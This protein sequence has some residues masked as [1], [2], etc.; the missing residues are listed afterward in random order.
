MRRPACVVHECSCIH[1]TSQTTGTSA[2]GRQVDRLSFIQGRKGRW[3]LGAIFALTAAW[4]AL[5]VASVFFLSEDSRPLRARLSVIIFTLAIGCVALLIENLS[6]QHFRMLRGFQAIHRHVL[7]C[8]LDGNVINEIQ[9][10]LPGP[11]LDTAMSLIEDIQ[12][13]C[14]RFETLENARSAAEVRARRNKAKYEHF[15]AVLNCLPEPV[16]VV[17]QFDELVQANPVARR[18]FGMPAG[19]LEKQKLSQAIDCPKLVDILIDT[20]RRK[21]ATQRTGEIELPDGDDQTRSF[22]VI[23]RTLPAKN[24]GADSQKGASQG[25]VAVL[26]DISGSKAAQKRNAEFVSAVSHEMKTPLSGIKA[27][28]ELLVDGDAE[29]EQTREDFLHVI[30]SQANRLQ[31]L[32]DNLLNLARIEAGVVQVSKQPLSLNELLDETLNI[33]RPAAEAKQITLHCDLS[34]LYL[35][36]LA[37]RDMLIQAAIN[38]LSNAIKY[39]APGGRVTLRSRMQDDRVSFSVEDSGVGLSPEDQVKV[40]EKFY[41]VAKDREMASGTGLGLPLALHIVED[42]HGGQLSVQSTLGRGSTFTIQLPAPAQL[43]MA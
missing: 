22:S 28:V 17:D 7:E 2:R 19:T 1:R 31:R 24:D 40:F 4:L 21:G 20:R 15:E 9:A 26:R 3:L 43:Q 10:M 29:D 39:T 42:V 12:G 36:V 41:R 27:Y 16:L 23:A 18:M 33:V 11:G 13:M 30:E 14:Q 8:S 5:W 6:Q 35:G 32:I 37:D 38:L 25:V 34:N